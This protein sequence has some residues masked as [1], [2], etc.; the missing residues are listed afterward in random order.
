[1]VETSKQVRVDNWGI[2]F[3]QRLQ[4]FFSKTDFCDLT[5]QFDGNVQL[6]VH[7]LV[8]NA[9]T[10]YFTFLEQN[11]PAPEENAILMPSELQAD[12][13]V[14]IVNFMY[15]G[16]LEFHPSIY[17]KLMKAADTMSI[18][19]LSKLLEA[20]LAP[21]SKLNS[22]N[23]RSSSNTKAKEVEKSSW[24][25]N[26]PK[27]QAKIAPAPV[28]N[29]L[30][31]ALP[32]KKVPVWKNRNPPSVMQTHPASGTYSNKWKRE[33][34]LTERKTVTTPNVPKP[35]RFEWPEEELTPIPNLYPTFEDVSLTSKPLW[36]KEDDHKP[37]IAEPKP[38]QY[39]NRKRARSIV[40]E[41][42][43][44]KEA[45]VEV[46]QL[47]EPAVETPAVK[48]KA[49]QKV[50]TSP[51]RIKITRE[52]E[53][54]IINITT[55]NPNEVDHKKIVTEILKKYPDLVN[56]KRN[57]KLKI[58]K[59][60]PSP[61]KVQAKEKV[62]PPKESPPA[63]SSPAPKEIKKEPVS[64]KKPP[65]REAAKPKKQKMPIFS[66]S[67]EEGPWTCMECVG[68][69]RDC[70]EFVL[71]Y[72][73]RKHMADQHHMEFDATLC[74]YCGKKCVKENHMTYHLY[75]KH[76]LKPPRDVVFP[77]CSKCP[78]IAV[79]NERLKEHMKIHSKDN[80]Q[81]PG[82]QLG[83]LSKKELSNHQHIS[84]HTNKV[85]TIF[86][87]TY[88]KKKL[89][90]PV[91]LFTHVRAQHIKQAARD[92]ITS[93]QEFMD[94]ENEEEDGLD[95]EEEVEKEAEAEKSQAEEL[96][97]MLKKNSKV[98]FVEEI[99]MEDK[100]L[101][102]KVKIIS[103]V[104]VPRQEENSPKRI[105]T[106]KATITSSSTAPETAVAVTTTTGTTISNITSSQ[107]TT[108]L[109]I[110][111][112]VV[113]DDNQQYIL[114]PPQGQSGNRDFILPHNLAG[115][116][117]ILQAAAA[118]STDE[119]VMVLT[120]DYQDQQAH[121]PSDNSNIVVLYSHP[122][123]GQEG[124]FITSQ[125]NILVNS[126][127]MLEIRNGT[128]I[129]T[130]AGGQLLV[131][132]S[133]TT[134]TSNQIETIDS[135]RKEIE[136]SHPIEI[137]EVKETAQFEK[138][139]PLPEGEDEP[140]C[141]TSSETLEKNEEQAQD[142]TDSSI[143][144]EP[145]DTSEIESQ[146]REN[147]KEE[148]EA[149]MIGDQPNN[150][151]EIEELQAADVSKE[152]TAEPTPSDGEL[153]MNDPKNFASHSEDREELMEVE[154]AEAKEFV[155]NVDEV[156]NQ[157]ICHSPS[158]AEV[159]NDENNQE[160]ALEEMNNESETQPL[161]ENFEIAADENQLAEENAAENDKTNETSNSLNQP[162]EN[163]VNDSNDNIQQSFEDF[164]DESQQSS[165]QRSQQSSSQTGRKDI[166]NKAILDDWE[167]TDSQQSNH[168]QEPESQ[169]Q[170]SQ[171]PENQ[172]Q[173]SQERASINAANTVNKLLMADW[174]DDEEDQNK[175]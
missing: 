131:N 28:V 20:Q 140:P 171:E 87:C 95:Y 18:S 158:T 135:I 80:I 4:L 32:G 124:Q 126:D 52:E 112:I 146:D 34:S 25:D 118:N 143:Q 111:D 109:G 74:K 92:G 114:Q 113:L 16:M 90:S 123:E 30:P 56:K 42:V 108:D 94:V 59:A 73:F 91:T 150:N 100:H 168:P 139:T 120:D 55:S 48:R 50:L 152:A 26:K 85:C 45:K 43:P 147:E 141:D 161:E 17:D 148:T 40:E 82:C 89:Q 72:L 37:D 169:D 99:S 98:E 39:S 93:L 2:Y 144:D 22:L 137:T 159:A 10:E 117:G 5:L 35:T 83:F 149:S 102:D 105:V 119:L 125:G 6:K 145:M 103:N 46:A 66:A 68:Q 29:D 133:T 128:A 127:G 77:K 160:E 12:V 47:E 33:H 106:K 110:V 13:M 173:D 75:T 170:D 8:M 76:G 134:R 115:N 21:I 19:V 81:C 41:P 116:E 107:L 96:S 172:D 142:A 7:R 53:E 44:E 70:A 9:C 122:V 84:R 138:D 155:E 132:D 79:T 153:V 151:E 167:D 61:N 88:C 69:D 78:F 136:G 174:E 60:D 71:Y 15:T 121:G 14:P 65:L 157:E 156:D 49:E 51:K 3:L 31:A 163:E 62:K 58:T 63:P 57:I 165:S 24:R 64:V 154:D 130:T 11:C 38:T 166:I 162:G 67:S 27:K 101:K 23:A 97:E 104:K 175:E 1:M 36:T 86:E 129:T 164:T 54:T